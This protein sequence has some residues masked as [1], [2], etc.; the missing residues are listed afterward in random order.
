MKY[1]LF[2]PLHNSLTA[3]TIIIGLSLGPNL[4]AAQHIDVS[5]KD[6]DRLN[7]EDSS[8]SAEYVPGID[9][10]GKPVKNADIETHKTFILPDEIVIPIDIDVAKEFDLGSSGILTPSVSVGTIKL[11]AGSIYL[12][13]SKLPTDTVQLIKKTCMEVYGQ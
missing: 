13:D 9:V 2:V 6:C 11:K 1:Y 4:S 5:R 12:N 10:R 3:L 8:V 7:S